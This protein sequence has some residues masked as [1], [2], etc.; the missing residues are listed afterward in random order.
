[1]KPK[2]NEAMD[3]RQWLEDLRRHTEGG[4]DTPPEDWWGG[5]ERRM[6]DRAAAS[7]RRR[8][9]FGWIGSGAVAAAAVALVLLLGGDGAMTP[10]TPAGDVAAPIIAQEYREPTAALT[11]PVEPSTG[12]EPVTVAEPRHAA[13]RQ[14]ETP[15]PRATVPASTEPEAVAASEP[16]ATPEPEPQQP[17]KPATETK[18]APERV[19][20]REPVPDPFAQKPTPTP[21]RK[22]LQAG[23]FASNISSS[24]TNRV[25][26]G[27]SSYL[28]SDVTELT[29]TDITHRLPVTVGLTLNLPLGGRWSISTGL[30]Y[31]LLSSQFRT[32]GATTRYSVD[33]VLH[34]IGIP[35]GVNY[36]LW[37]GD[38]LTVYLSAGGGVE[39]S[40]SGSA[41]FRGMVGGVVWPEQKNAISDKPQWSLRGAAGLQYD[42]SRTLGLYAEPGV[43]Y[44]FNNRSALETIYKTKPL[45]FALRLGLR[46]SM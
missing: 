12:D 28:T 15:S 42:F 20:P 25:G 18:P 23:L 13:P 31:T 4:A 36:A 27:S 37:Q 35:L 21:K 5:V 32:E 29:V 24:N 43:N 45:N 11:E 2:N 14:P 46:F 39:K 7:R 40:V 34:N 41:T 44:Y 22:R 1:M 8:A 6:N 19:V 33:Q 9:V 10:H 17:A 16:V 30:N 26:G 3:E 38:R